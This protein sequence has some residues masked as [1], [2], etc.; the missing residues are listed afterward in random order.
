V[1]TVSR[2]MLL[3]LCLIL[4][5]SIVAQT[6]DIPDPEAWF[7]HYM[8]QEGEI[9]DYERSLEYYRLM[10]ERSD[11]IIYERIGTTTDGNPFVLLTISSPNNLAELEQ[12]RLD[13]KRLTDPRKTSLQEARSLAAKLPAVVFHTS[14][15]HSSEISTAQVVPEVVHKLVTSNDPKI[16]EILE[17]TIILYSPSQNPDGQYK[18]NRWYNQHKGQPWE[19][20]LPELYHTY[21]G[22]DNNRDWVLLHFNEQ[23][24]VA[25]H[26]HN[27]W[28][29][30]YSHEMHEFGGTAARIFVP[31]YQ[32]PYDYNVAPQVIAT[33]NGM[34][35]AIATRLTALG[36]AGVV[37]NAHFDLFTP[38]RAYQVYRG[39][40]RLLTET[41]SGNFARTSTISQEQ[42]DRDIRGTGHYNPTRQS[43]NFP[44]IWG[45]GDW[46]FRDRVEYQVE[47]NFALM[48]YAASHRQLF[49]MALYN[50]FAHTLNQTEWPAGYLIPIV[51]QDPGTT[52][53]LLRLMQFG[54]IEIHRL[55][56]AVTID[57]KKY[58]PG[59]YFISLQQPYAAWVKTLFERQSYPDYRQDPDDPPIP[60]YDIT[61][62]TLP[63]LM[64]VNAIELSEADTLSLEP[65]VEAIGIV[66][67]APAEATQGYLFSPA[68]NDSYTL[69]L[70]LLG[71]GI[72]VQRLSSATTVS[73]EKMPAGSFWVRCSAE[74]I[75]TAAA[76]LALPV[77]AATQ[78]PQVSSVSLS[79]PRIGIYEP[80]GGLMDAGWTRKMF[81]DY[82]FECTTIRNADFRENRLA[83]YDV[84]LFP[85]G[86]SPA[87][88]VEGSENFP[89][90]YRGGIGDSGVAALKQ[91]V[92]NGGTV[93]S[94]GQSNSSLVS[95]LGIV[96]KDR[97]QDL[98][99]ADYF[100][101]GA[102]V[103]VNFDVSHPVNYGMNPVQ[104]AVLRYVPLLEVEGA[105]ELGSFVSED[106]A[107]S[108]F[109]LGAEH[110]AGSPAAIVVERGKGTVVMFTFLPQFRA[111]TAGTYKQIFN[112][113]L[114]AAQNK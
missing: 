24:L 99:R 68:V 16:H 46:T 43:W 39:T 6:E 114:Q 10:A 74:Q 96:A 100:D 97:R 30:V 102:I 111:M 15:I 45:P 32:D 84:I 89:E 67:P 110:I 50:G 48:Q 88:L 106:L 86:L 103:A 23:R 112:V 36:Y 101:P 18:Y 58:M 19:G 95:A 92:E 14:S 57:G 80:W 55:T 75:K 26:V 82:E 65:V 93:A 41:A 31:P 11:R 28:N 81:E 60:P 56:A 53:D 37:Q 21:I 83:E 85:N 27:K 71:Q 2:N 9:I 4:T 90:E 107:L 44:Y 34:G 49:S 70:R 87:Q 1:N 13:R 94:W 47:T 72:A 22:H 7:G 79:V 63:L 5:G 35:T 20:I 8:G 62:H 108:G 91:F 3:I 54:D 17:N 105:T 98:S 69:T 38:A 77:I 73:G 40:A 104:A 52:Q 109:L 78:P 29:P 12:F 66:F 61:G 33:M 59:S 113:C 64:N 51:Q 25:E 42:L 76:D